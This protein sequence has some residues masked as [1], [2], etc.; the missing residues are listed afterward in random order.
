[1]SSLNSLIAEYHSLIGKDHHKDRDCHFHIDKN[2][3]YGKF[4]GYSVWHDGYC[5]KV[6]INLPSYEEAENFLST[7]L[8]MWINQEKKKYV[9]IGF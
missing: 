7:L 8:V 2:W 1:M 6:S 9:D 3:S 4:I 5:N